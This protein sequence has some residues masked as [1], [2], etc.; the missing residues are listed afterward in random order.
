MISMTNKLIVSV[1]AIL[2]LS[3]PASVAQYYNGNYGGY[4]GG[5]RGYESY[6]RS[7][8]T[9]RS[10]I[11]SHT[12]SS[13]NGGSYNS[14]GYGSNNYPP[15]YSSGNWYSY[16]PGYV[17]GNYPYGGSYGNSGSNAWS[18]TYTDNYNR[19]YNE[20]T[21]E[22]IK[23]D[24]YIAYDAGGLVHSVDGGFGGRAGNVLLAFGVN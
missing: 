7:Y 17:Y 20:K 9:V 15:Y 19:Q 6:Q 18:N 3:L 4:Y 10:D 23:V 1:L 22:L 13:T 14:N 21:N 8:D 16:Q 5:D 11:G 12:V 2:L 24:R